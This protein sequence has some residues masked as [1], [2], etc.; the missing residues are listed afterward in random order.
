MAAESKGIDPIH[1]FNI[2]RLFDIRLGGLDASFTNSSLFMLVVFVCITALMVL[3]TSGRHIVPTRLQAAAEMAYE[4]VASTVRDTTGDAGMRFFP[5]VFS[6]FMFVL[7]SNLIGLIPGAF[8]VTSQIVVTFAFAALIIGI[9]TAAWIWLRARAD[10]GAQLDIDERP[11]AVTAPVAKT[12]DPTPPVLEPVKPKIDVAEPVAFVAAP[13]PAPP[14]PPAPG[15]GAGAV[16]RPAI[17][18]A[19]GAPDN[20]ELI[21]GV[22]PKLNKLLIS[23]GITRFDQIAAWGEKEIE[24]VDRFLGAFKGRITRDSWVEQAGYLAKGD[25][26][27]FSAKF[28]AVGSEIK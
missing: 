21:K 18:P 3:S 14:P 20:L 28:G 22:G 4:F 5:L 11:A 12:P 8:T 7:F 17:P 9:A 24:E 1:Q 19:V 6:L 23:L 27:G 10:I 15:A 2:D 25:H 26:D 16:D 13:E